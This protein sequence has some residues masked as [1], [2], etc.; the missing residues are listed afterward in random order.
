MVAG[1]ASLLRLARI[2]AICGLQPI[3]IRK[4]A[5]IS[6]GRLRSFS[7]F[8]TYPQDASLT[9][10]LTAKKLIALVQDL[11]TA[12]AAG[13]MNRSES[14]QLMDLALQV[15]RLASHVVEAVL[16]G[17]VA[18]GS[19]AGASLKA[20]QQDPVWSRPYAMHAQAYAPLF[21]HGPMLHLGI[22]GAIA[23]STWPRTEIE[24]LRRALSH[25][26]D[27][28]HAAHVLRRDFDTIV[29]EAVTMLEKLQEVRRIKSRSSMHVVQI[30]A[31]L[32]A[33]QSA[34]SLRGKR[35]IDLGAGM[36]E[37]VSYLQ[38]EGA[39]V[40]SSELVA[41]SDL[42]FGIPEQPRFDVVFATALMEPGAFSWPR[43]GLNL[44]EYNER[45]DELVEAAARLLVPG[46]YLVVRNLNH[47]LPF[48]N[49]AIEASCLHYVPTLLPFCTPSFGGRMAVWRKL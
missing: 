3:A 30:E 27:V 8:D 23:Q 39:L 47:P 1:F 10:Q 43:T 31:Y 49:V 2:G 40:Q 29:A 46:G 33:L 17:E 41:D 42:L 9:P 18:S 48:S 38:S 24:N 7:M 22:L 25:G 44:Q 45:S 34:G 16:E 11:V 20:H 15:P 5:V 14:L 13:A 36:G 12:P 35:C 21:K 26:A 4:L 28:V 6:R 32:A 37:L 19:A